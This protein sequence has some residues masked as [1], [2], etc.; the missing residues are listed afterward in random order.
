[1]F[2]TW[3]QRILL[4]IYILLIISIPIGTYYISQQTSFKG[5]AKEETPKIEPVKIVDSKIKKTP[6]PTQSAKEELKKSSKE[7]ATK[8]PS[9]SSTPQPSEETIATTFGPTLSLK[10]EIE[11][12]PKG[13]QKDKLFVGI[14]EGAVS[15][16]PK[17]LLTFSVDLPDNGQFSN[18]SLAGLTS[19]SQYTALL[20]GS[21]SIATSSAFVMT[22]TQTLL[23]NNSPI[24]LL[25]GDLNEDNVINASDFAIAKNALGAQNPSI[26]W[27][28]A[29]DF[30]KDGLINS[31]DLSIV[32]KNYGKAGDSGAWTSPIPKV[33]TKSASLIPSV[34]SAQSDTPPQ[35]HPTETSGY[36]IWV[37]QLTK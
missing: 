15:L 17:F 9:P 6:T 23:N 11:G 22:P 37:P 32:I 14:I 8:S 2:S 31:L 26:K 19:N 13:K 30:N 10:V 35:G 36:W 21:S 33:A 20:K 5:Q 34:A 25:S 16:N 18:L 29:V 27:N 4:G 1:M 24:F 12:R 3:P 28:E 7:T